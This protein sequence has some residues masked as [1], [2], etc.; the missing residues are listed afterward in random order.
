MPGPRETT[1]VAIDSALHRLPEP[2]NG[3]RALVPPE[4]LG[5]MV[6]AGSGQITLQALVALLWYGKPQERSF[7]TRALHRYA[8]L[9]WSRWMLSEPWSDIYGRAIVCC[10]LA[11]VL[12]AERIGDGA[13]AALICTVWVNY[14]MLRADFASAR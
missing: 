5:A 1:D 3:W 4:D 10:W 11:V 6:D 2:A 14:L 13:L 8:D 7:A 12:I 9:C